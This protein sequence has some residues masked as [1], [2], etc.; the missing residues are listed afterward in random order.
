M[1]LHLLKE[2]DWV[3]STV[4]QICGNL[5]KTKLIVAKVVLQ[6]SNILDN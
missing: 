4:N 1:I 3:T 2:Q 6:L 5:L